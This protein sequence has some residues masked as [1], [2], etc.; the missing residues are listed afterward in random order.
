[1]RLPFIP[2]FR[3]SQYNGWITITGR[4]E[5]WVGGV[6]QTSERYDDLWRD[7]FAR[8]EDMLATPVQNVLMLGLAGGG[9]LQ[10]VEDAY[11]GT[12]VTVI[13]IDPVMVDIAKELHKDTDKTYRFPTVLVGDAKEVLEKMQS[14]YDVILIDIFNGIKPSP[15]VDDDYF[16]SLVSARLT[17]GGVAVLNVAIDSTRTYVA[18][19]HFKN[20]RAWRYDANYFCALSNTGQ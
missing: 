7:A 5:V 18:Q 15:L 14:T 11:P 16:W 1:M 4:G 10:A 3:R 6:K 8:S 13:E 19:N 17:P 12:P 20:T 2:Y 9:A